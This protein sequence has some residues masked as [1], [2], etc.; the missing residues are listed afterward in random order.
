MNKAERRQA[1]YDEL[2]DKL[3]TLWAS[4][5]VECSRSLES[6]A[7]EE[8]RLERCRGLGDERQATAFPPPESARPV[9]ENQFG[10]DGL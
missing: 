7:Q 2:L 4:G 10:I 6:E 3:R 5:G 1:K 8:T 9:H